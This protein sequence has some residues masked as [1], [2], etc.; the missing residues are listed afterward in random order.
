MGESMGT[1]GRDERGAEPPRAPAESHAG[2]LAGVTVQPLDAA[3][4][5][6][7]AVPSD[8]TGVVVASIA[9]DSVAAATELEPGDV[10]LQIDHAPTPTVQTFERAAAGVN[11][12]VLLLI[13]RKGQTLFLAIV[14]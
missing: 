2:L 12:Q 1:A 3:L 13:F 10:I 6:K 14:R 7:Y 9:P 8:V 5:R 11:D 4:R